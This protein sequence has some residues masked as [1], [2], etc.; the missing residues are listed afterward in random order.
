MIEITHTPTR[1]KLKGVPQPLHRYPDGRYVVSTSKHERD[2][3]RVST[4]EEALTHIQRGL[5]GRFGDKRPS[6]V[7]IV[8]P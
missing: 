8:R 1:G 3:I 7:K 6:F 2:Y 5:G 4:Q